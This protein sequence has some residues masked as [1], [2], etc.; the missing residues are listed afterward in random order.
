MPRPDRLTKT[1]LAHWNAVRALTDQV[2]G[3][4]SRE[5]Q[6]DAGLS[7]PDFEVL[8]A[9]A[10]FGGEAVRQQVLTDTAGWQ[11]SRMSHH[12]NRMADRG[13][14]ARTGADG[15]VWIELTAAGEE[16]LAAA[17]LVQVRAVRAQLR[18]LTRDQLA[19]LATIGERLTTPVTPRRGRG[20][21]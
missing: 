7:D 4:V 6:S 1:E 3:A 20:A 13:L 12:L 2:R 11:K 14:V 18:R 9:L 19:T 5:V 16:A 17:Q 15:G 10:E 8:S 21:S